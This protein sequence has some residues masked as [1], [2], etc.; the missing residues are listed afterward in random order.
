MAG[1]GEAQGA[2]CTT[3]LGRPRVVAIMEAED[4]AGGEG[5]SHG[6]WGRLCMMAIRDWRTDGGDCGRPRDAGFLRSIFPNGSLLVACAWGRAAL[7][8]G[9]LGR[10]SSWSFA[11]LQENARPE[12]EWWEDWRRLLLRLEVSMEMVGGEV[13]VV[14]ATEERVSLEGWEHEIRVEQRS[15]GCWKAGQDVVWTGD[16]SDMGCFLGV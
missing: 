12:E 2:E 6:R 14:D 5:V 9:R 13:S 4:T 1:K 3:W 10:I 16:V 15:V 8:N 7:I 11:I